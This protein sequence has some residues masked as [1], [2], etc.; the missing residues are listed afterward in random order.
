MHAPSPRLT[1]NGVPPTERKART[2][3]FTPPGM[4]SSDFSNRTSFLVFM[5]A[6]SGL[7]MFNEQAGE[8]PCRDLDI[9]RVEYRAD[10]RQGVGARF[11][12]SGSVV[13]RDAADRD[14]RA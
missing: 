13:R 4:T 14:N 8:T 5:L 9:G 7:V 6:V 2:G 12:Q 3:E 1:N 11:D 10:Y